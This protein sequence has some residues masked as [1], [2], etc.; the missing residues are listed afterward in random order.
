MELSESTA[1]GP[2][3][4]EPTIPRWVKIGFYGTLTVLAGIANNITFFEMGQKMGP[5]PMF[6]LYFS[7]MLYV[8]LYGMAALVK[9]AFA[10]N[11][12]GATA[13]FYRK[14]V[15]PQH[16]KRLVAVGVW[17]IINGLF[18]Q[19]ANPYVDG[20]LQGVLYQVGEIGNTWLYCPAICAGWLLSWIWFYR[21]DPSVARQGACV[22]EYCW[23]ASRC[24]L[25][26]ID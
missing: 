19:F 5:Y 14:F 20:N 23:S 16:Q 6:L 2:A 22:V 4:S 21:P 25:G 9:V 3:S 13:S 15:L 26:L 17:L 12:P 7:T 11:Q 8:T 1:K 10:R 18:S 24:F